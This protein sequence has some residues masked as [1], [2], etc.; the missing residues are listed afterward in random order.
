MTNEV[1]END[2]LNLLINRVNTLKLKL[3][4][5]E[6]ALA[7][8]KGVEN[9]KEENEK[10]AP[11]LTYS[12]KYTWNKKILFVLS[13]IDSAY[14]VEIIKEIQLL[15]PKKDFKKLANLIS[16]KLSTLLKKGIVKAERDGRRFKYKLP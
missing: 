7:V 14:T 4:R 12:S 10:T 13:K 1:T 5:A 2:V 9:I 15:E 11:P 8:F 6:E 16:V 3:K